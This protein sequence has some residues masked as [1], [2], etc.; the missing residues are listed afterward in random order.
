MHW[1]LRITP[2]LHGHHFFVKQPHPRTGKPTRYATPLLLA[3]VLV[4]GADI[5]F[6]VDS[7]P[8]IFVIT[9]DPYIIYTSNIF[10]VLG[11]RALYFAIAAIVHRFHYLKYA[12]A[13]ILVFIGGKIFAADL[14]G[15]HKIPG[16][17]SLAVTITLILGGILYSLW[18]TRRFAETWDTLRYG[19]R[20][21][22]LR[23]RD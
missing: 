14:L 5:I 3:L 15:L 21:Y 1:A 6:A 16:V 12:I 20:V 8:A 10:A 9:T 13:L 17:V 7:V 19:G 4:E 11:L 22:I 23:Q 18:R 2:E